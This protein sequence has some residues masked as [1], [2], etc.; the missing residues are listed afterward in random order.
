MEAVKCDRCGCYG[1]KKYHEMNITINGGGRSNFDL[2]QD[3]CPECHD[4]LKKWWLD[5]G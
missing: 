5:N 2:K 1:D 3:I 4:S